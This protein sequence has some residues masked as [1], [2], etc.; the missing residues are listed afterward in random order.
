MT[1]NVVTISTNHPEHNHV[2]AV[3][4]GAYVVTG[5]GEYEIAGT[6]IVGAATEAL[7]VSPRDGQDGRPPNTAY[8]FEME[9]LSVCHLGCMAE[10]PDQAQVEQFD[11]ID[12]LLVPVGGK[13]A[14][15]GAKAA[16]TVNLL[17]PRIVIPM[18][19][20]APDLSA[21]LGTVTR[22]LTEMA[23]EKPD[24]VESLSITKAQLPDDTRVI[25]LEPRREPP[26]PPAR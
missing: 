12:I 19:Y 24:V 15:T 21:S 23:V 20:R 13:A 25:L 2:A 6:Y 11:G 1:A 5:P 14:L 16:E 3:R 7:S 26:R 8:L 9:D 18:Y 10:V 17:E 4:A 22:F